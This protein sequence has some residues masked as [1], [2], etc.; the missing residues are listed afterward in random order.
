MGT[1]TDV[2]KLPKLM[3]Y[4]ISVSR[5]FFSFFPRTEYTKDETTNARSFS[6]NV[7][8]TSSR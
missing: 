4:F 1:S 3:D 7:P 6:R 8:V 2:A 5:T